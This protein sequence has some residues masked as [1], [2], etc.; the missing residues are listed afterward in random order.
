M[1]EMIL[2]QDGTEFNQYQ[3]FH[4][5]DSLQVIITYLSKHV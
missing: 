2:H 4:Y 3:Y 1:N 5:N